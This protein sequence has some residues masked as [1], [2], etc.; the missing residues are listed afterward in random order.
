MKQKFANLGH[1]YL[2]QNIDTDETQFYVENMVGVPSINTGEFFVAT[3]YTTDSFY[4]TN[5]EIVKVVQTDGNYWTVERNHE[6]SGAKE[7]LQGSRIE[8]RL[9]AGSVAELA[10]PKEWSAPTVTK[11][12]AEDTSGE[13]RRA[14]TVTRVLE[15]NQAWWKRSTMKIKLDGVATGATANATDAQLRDRASHTGTQ[16]IATVVGLQDAL[17]DL[18]SSVD[19]LE[20]GLSDLRNDLSASTISYNYT[21]ATYDLSKHRITATHKACRRC[22]LS[23]DGNVNY[24]LDPHDSNKKEDGTSADLTGGDGQVMVEI[25]RFWFGF[26][27][28]GE[29][30]QVTQSPIPLPGLIP[31]PVFTTGGDFDTVYV[32]A[33]NATVQQPD[34]TIIPGLNLDN[35][36]ARVSLEVDKLSSLSGGDNYAMIGLNLDE[37]RILANNRGEGWDE[38]SFLAW[39][40]L[41]VLGYTFLGSFNGQDSLGNGNVSKSYPASSSTQSESPH[42]LNGASNVLGNEAGATNDFMSLLGVE[43]L[44][45]QCWQWVDG[46]LF[47]DAQVYVSAVPA[48]TITADYYPVGEAISQAGTSGEYISKF[49]ELSNSIMIPGAG[50][51]DSSRFVGDS[52]WWNVGLRGARV[53]CAANDGARCGLACLSALAPGSRGRHIGGRVMFKRSRG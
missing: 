34:G 6:E 17:S 20:S 31:H 7:H 35:N 28:I 32:G 52:F 5:I 53:G 51:G 44:W 21:T 11:E 1:G 13:A 15:A 39:Q 27:H 10:K 12:E 38:F 33:Y 46:V 23:D 48:S 25:P 29:T 4:G 9:T 8:L 18:E 37:F 36:T 43:N 50:G 19:G 41:Q 22:L 24:Y 14:W 42:T 40:A 26:K 3:I 49:Q 47:Q 30:I 16:A 45:G 2:A